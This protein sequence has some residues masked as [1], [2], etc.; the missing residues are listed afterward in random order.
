MLLRGLERRFEA[1]RGFAV[2]RLLLVVVNSPLNEPHLE[3]CDRRD[4][5]GQMT[6]PGKRQGVQEYFLGHGFSGHLPQ[7]YAP[8]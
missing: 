8:T 6:V 5:L 4:R 2:V 7:V 1:E 3:L